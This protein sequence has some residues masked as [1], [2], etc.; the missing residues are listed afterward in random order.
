MEIDEE[1]SRTTACNEPAHQ[2]LNYCLRGET[3][4]PA[5][6]QSLIRDDCTDALFRIVVERLADLFEPH[7]CEA[8]AKLFSE[9]IAAAVPGTDP[10]Q[11]LARY[12]RVRRARKFDGEADSIRKVF[13]LSR[14]TLGA[15]VAITSV[16]LDGLKRRFP[17]ADIVFTGSRKAWELFAAD[18]LAAEPLAAERRIAHAPISYPRA[19][20]LRDR[21]APW[22]ELKRL[23]SAPNSIV[24]DPDS[25]LTQLGLLPVCPEEC[26]YFFESRSYGGEGD[27][28]LTK[29]TQR[30]VAATFGVQTACPYIAPRHCEWRIQRPHVSISLG[31]GENPA[32][33][34]PDAFEQK[35]L[36]HVTQSGAYVTIDKGAG[37][38]EAGRVER[39]IRNLRAPSDRM[40]VWEGSFAGFA[41]IIA[42]SDLYIGYDSAGQHVAA[43]CGVPLIAVFAGFPS[44]RMFHRW[45]PTGRGK[46]EVIRVEGACDPERVLSQSLLAFDRMLKW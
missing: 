32:K 2:L 44:S 42:R 38:E 30:W 21:L 37:G 1:P 15:D 13:V 25:R 24:I 40:Q 14:V 10:A 36:A 22:H 39:A 19:R 26:Y 46:V 27:E 34:M 7:L 41:S 23:F 35:L 11:L 3:W 33:R 17:K 9:A 12:N 6:L 18:P 16:I 28:S 8:Y 45:R 43:A 5:L 29:L 20:S 31:V 4:P